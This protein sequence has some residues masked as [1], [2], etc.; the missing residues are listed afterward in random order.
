MLFKPEHIE[1]IR[2][3]RKTATRRDWEKKMVKVDG[4]YPCQTEMFQPKDECD[5][6][7]RVTDLYKQRLGEMTLLD[8][9]KEGYYGFG[10][11]KKAWIEINGW[12]DMNREVWVVE[13]QEV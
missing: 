5:V 13:F 7:I 11:F 1:M 6:F 10:D 4:V 3:G 2:E 8:A 9:L 12:W